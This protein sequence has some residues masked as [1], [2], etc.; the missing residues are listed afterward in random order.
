MLQAASRVIKENLNKE[1]L[2]QP[3]LQGQQFPIF[4][5]EG[6]KLNDEDV[7]QAGRILRLLQIHSVRQIQ[8]VINETIVNVQNITADPKTDS[9][10]GKVGF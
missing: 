5:G 6:M 1:S 2:K 9:A 4:E 10:L 8:T 3:V 7:E